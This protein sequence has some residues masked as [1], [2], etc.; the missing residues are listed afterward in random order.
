MR[1]CRIK[2]CKN[3][4]FDFS[5]HGFKVHSYKAG[6]CKADKKGDPVYYH[7]CCELYQVRIMWKL[8]SFIFKTV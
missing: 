7:D 3:W 2:E 1:H 4:D 8:R 5:N 6:L